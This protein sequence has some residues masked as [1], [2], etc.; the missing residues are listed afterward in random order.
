VQPFIY[1]Q[2]IKIQLS[3][4]AAWC[5][6]MW[7]RTTFIFY[8]VYN[9]YFYC[10]MVFIARTMLSQDV[11]PSD[12]PSVIRQTPVL[13]RWTY[14]QTI[15]WSGSHTI[16]FWFFLTKRYGNI[17]TGTPIMGASNELQGVW[18]INFWPISRFISEIIQDRA[19]SKRSNGTILLTLSDLAKYSTTWSICIARSL[20]Q[21]SLY[22][23]IT[24][25][26]IWYNYEIP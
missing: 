6:Y 23:Y 7:F 21:L 2:I 18:K 14:P 26:L 8:Y 4:K 10:A 12:R 19:I 22:I 24:T 3:F 5:I 13:C 1:I 15:S 9:L 16:K 25:I 20:R 17:V 11:R